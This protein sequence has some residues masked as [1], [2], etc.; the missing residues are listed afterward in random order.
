MIDRYARE[1]MKNIWSDDGKYDRWLAVEIAACEAWTRMGTIPEDD[2]ALIRKATW[3]H[4]KLDEKFVQ[5]RHDVTAFLYSVTSG[6]GAEGTLGSPGVDLQRR[7]G[8]GDGAAIAG[9]RRP[10][11]HRKSTRSSKPSLRGLSSISTRSSW[12]V[13]TEYTRSPRRSG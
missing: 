6:L 10:A 12:A 3:D 5:T 2:M 4:A 1:A 9:R 8:Y 13:P 7:M 11:A